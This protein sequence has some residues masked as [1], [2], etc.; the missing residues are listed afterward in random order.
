MGNIGHLEEVHDPHGRLIRAPEDGKIHVAEA[1]QVISEILLVIVEVH[2]E[3]DEALCFELF[4][5]GENFGQGFAAI[6]ASGLPKIKEDGFSAELGEAD[7]PAGEVREGEI[8]GGEAG[9]NPLRRLPKAEAEE[10]TR[11]GEDEEDKGHSPKKEP[12]PPESTEH[13]GKFKGKGAED[14]PRRRGWN[15]ATS[16]IKPDA[17]DFCFHSF[18]ASGFMPDE[19]VADKPRRHELK[20]KRRG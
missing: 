19:N 4:A 5:Q 14:E 9:L 3:E 12:L 17:T 13:R 18:V 6:G 2:G 7:F 11:S 8:R 10:C 20:T 15:P 1:V 16:G